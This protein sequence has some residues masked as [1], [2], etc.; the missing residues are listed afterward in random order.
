MAINT[1]N[2]CKYPWQI[3]LIVYMHFVLNF[4]FR[5]LSYLINTTTDTEDLIAIFVFKQNLFIAIVSQ[6]A[7]FMNCNVFFLEF[8]SSVGF[9]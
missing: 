1:P 7:I 8:L 4:S 5:I 6:D 2:V 9:Y 3:F